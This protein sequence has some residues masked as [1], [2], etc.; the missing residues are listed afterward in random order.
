R[1]DPL[2]PHRDLP[3]AAFGA[4]DGLLREPGAP[5]RALPPGDGSGGVGADPGGDERPRDLRLPPGVGD[6]EPDLP[7]R[8]Q[9]Q[10]HSARGAAARLDAGPAGPPPPRPAPPGPD[11]AAG[12]ESA[13]V[14]GRVPAALLER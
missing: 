13:L 7:R 10:A 9:P 8:R 1:G 6:G 14:L 2:A 3:G 12:L 4:T 5:G 11:P